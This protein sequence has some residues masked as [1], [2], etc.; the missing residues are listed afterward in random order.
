MRLPYFLLDVFTQDRL[1]GNPLA[2]V[3]KAD[4]LSGARMQAL[5][6]E[7]NLSETVFVLAPKNE[8]HTNELRIFSPRNEMAFAGHPTIGAAVLL[9]LQS[10]MS[11]VR[12]ELGVGLVTAVMERIDKRTGEAKFALPRLP[13][14][15]G[16]APTDA[17][18]AQRLGLSE[19]D[20][21]CGGLRPAQ[22]SAGSS[23]HLVP[24]RDVSVLESIV[25]DHRG[26]EETFFGERCAVYV[27]TPTPNERGN[28]Y[29]AR[30]LHVAHGSGEDAA[31][32]S[33]AA[34]LI[35]LLAEQ[36]EFSDGHHTLKLRQGRE[37]GRP[38]LIEIQF[39]T[40]QGK[41]RHAGI[42]G[43]AVILAEGVIDLDD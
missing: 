13:E 25:P 14:R 3:L 40:E 27:F 12:L 23:F 24:V 9:G 31:T 38:S 22:Y 8:R 21:G 6:A 36:P 20:I 15:V 10:R 33:A 39:N 19:G 34:A 29:A 30:M 16:D 7:F 26:W 11:A 2:V 17:A 1:S 42:G 5:A 35:G 28:D 37:M 32:G 18:I 43:A 41:L 4:G